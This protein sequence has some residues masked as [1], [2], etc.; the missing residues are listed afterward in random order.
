AHLLGMDLATLVQD[1]GGDAAYAELAR[2]GRIGVYIE[3]GDRELAFVGLGD[4][5]EHRREHL[6]RPAPFRPEID[7][8]GILRL[9]YVLLERGVRNVFDEIAHRMSFPPCQSLAARRRTSHASHRLDGSLPQAAARAHDGEWALS[10][11]IQAVPQLN[12]SRS[13]SP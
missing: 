2:R 1:D 4:F 13:N 9:Q 10:D 3:L 8:H 5:I 7:Q 11:K 6:A 12:G